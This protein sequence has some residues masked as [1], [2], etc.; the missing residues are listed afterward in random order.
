[1]IFAF[2]KKPYPLSDSISGKIKA[3]TF[4]GL[5][6]FLFL[7]A[8]RPFQLHRFSNPL[9]LQLTVGYGM[10]TF[11]MVML[12]T[13]L[14]PKMLSRV[15]N[16][17]KWNVARE[18]GFILWIIFTIGIANALFS[19]LIFD[20]FFDLGY[21]LYF[22]FI[23]IMVAV[24]PVTINVMIMQ[25]ILTRRNLKEAQDI[26]DH[27]LHKKRLDATPDATV[28]LRSDS[29]KEELQLPVKDLLFITS[30]DNYIEVHFLKDGK[31][32]KKLLR[33]TLRNTRD[34]LRAYTA[35]YRCH[36]A[37][38]VNLDRVTSVTGNSQGYRL[39]LEGTET[40]IPV[41]RNLNDEI[42]NRL[43]R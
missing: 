12:N 25:L 39:L 6:V 11:I 41:S 1:M 4:T 19:I 13:I 35:F 24:L 21:L 31:E 36:R 3:A 40:I 27:M 17:N 22:Q 38:I 23:T 9:A 16:E 7:F 33:G 15:F 29:G 30:A 34:D 26:S 43:S 10:I 20:D 2:L 8:F 32:E 37:W 14:L 42:R 28:L 18:I 5:F